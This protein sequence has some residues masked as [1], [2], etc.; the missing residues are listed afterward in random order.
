M[1]GGRPFDELYA[2]GYGVGCVG[3]AGAL[4]RESHGGAWLGAEIVVFLHLGLPGC[5]HGQKDSSAHDLQE[6]KN[7]RNPE[8]KGRYN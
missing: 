2:I 6:A 7:R 3:T 8:A 5:A 4:N 1:A